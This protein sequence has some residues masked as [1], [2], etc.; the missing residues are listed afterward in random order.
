MQLLALEGLVISYN[1]KHCRFWKLGSQL[2][3]PPVHNS[4]CNRGYG[5]GVES[6][7]VP[8]LPS[9]TG[10]QDLNPGVGTGRVLMPLTRKMQDPFIG[11]FSQNFGGIF[12]NTLGGLGECQAICSDLMQ[13]S[14]CRLPYIPM[15]ALQPQYFPISKGQHTLPQF[16]QANKM[17]S[18]I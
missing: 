13:W 14:W 4:L 3:Q 15:K 16:T 5:P 6:H 1:L 12:A 11:K 18:L 2:L 8:P 7:D 9:I 10:I 17:D